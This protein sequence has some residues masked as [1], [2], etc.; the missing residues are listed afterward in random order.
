MAAK[1][2]IKNGKSGKF[3][4]NLKSANGQVVLSSE[5]YE[6]RKAAENGV[7]SVQKNAGNE[8]RFEIST[9]KDGRVYFVIKASNGE[10]I[11]RS[12]M[13]KDNAG[14]KRGIASVQKNGPS[15]KV[16]DVTT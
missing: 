8:K 9:A 15:A 5:Q 7:K 3:S 13:Y 6:T 11:G 2:E 1:F 10:V 12:Q 4:F 14:L 16:V